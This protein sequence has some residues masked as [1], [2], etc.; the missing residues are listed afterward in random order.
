MGKLFDG[1]PTVS[2]DWPGNPYQAPE[3]ADK[4]LRK[5]D[6]HVDLYSWA[7]ILVHAVTGCLPPKG[8]EG[9]SL[10]KITLSNRVRRIAMQCLAPDPADRPRRADHV[11]KAI[12]WWR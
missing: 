6:T 7:R 8:Q 5:E 10:D 11:L 2:R 3:V 9:P 1:S 12:R 4:S